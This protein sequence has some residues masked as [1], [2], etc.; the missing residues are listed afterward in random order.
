METEE[1][2]DSKAPQKKTK[3]A[4]SNDTAEETPGVTIYTLISNASSIV[5]YVIH[6]G[7]NIYHII[8][9]STSNKNIELIFLI[10][11][12]IL[13][14]VATAGVSAKMQYSDVETPASETDYERKKRGCW[15]KLAN[16]KV[17]FLWLA[18]LLQADIFLRCI[19]RMYYGVKIRMYRINGNEDN[20]RYYNAMVKDNV[21]LTL[22]IVIRSFLFS[23]LL[24]ILKMTLFFNQGSDSE[25]HSTIFFWC[26]TV[27]SLASNMI[28]Y[29]CAVRSAQPD[30]HR[31]TIFGLGIMLLWYSG[32][33]G[34]RILL[35]A[36]AASQWPLS[37]FLG[38]MLNWISWTYW[39]YSQK[40][41]AHNF[42]R[43]LTRSELT[44][45][46]HLDLSTFL[47]SPV[48][49]VVYTFTLVNFKEGS[50]FLRYCFYYVLMTLQNGTVLILDIYFGSSTDEF[51]VTYLY[52]FRI[53]SILLFITGIVAMLIYYMFVHP[54]VKCYAVTCCPV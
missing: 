43:E 40:D 47:F 9:Y 10:G 27:I 3:I 52:I 45:P 38:C 44:E 54:K 12:I 24:L 49:A 6:F 35:I 46:A 19:R 31:I 39:I 15:E 4:T 50:T 7:I 2:N 42:C 8:N 37:T 41:G 13:N 17:P 25:I 48:L 14:S 36:I 26:F 23:A 20:L 28:G 34:A 22:L 11:L 51:S 29:Q 5:G 16:L 21:N 1:E 30:K 32:T 53:L 33:I 18:V